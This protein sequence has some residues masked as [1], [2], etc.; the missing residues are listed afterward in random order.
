MESPV[1]G[2]LQ[3]VPLREVWKGEATD[4]TPWLEHNIDVL[5]DAVDLQLSNV[6]RE[7]SAGSFNVD[8]VAEDQN[9]SLVVIE[10][11]LEKSDHDHLGKLITYFTALDARTGIWI[12]SD[13]RPEHV[14]AVGWLNE[15]S[16][17]SFY[18]LKVEAVRIGGSQPAPL[19][20]L[21]TGPSEEAREAGHTKKELAE[22]YVIRQRF[23]TDLLDRS[24][25]RTKL[26]SNISPSQ[27]GWI[28][29]GAGASPNYS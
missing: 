27:S 2:K 11:Q 4:F 21:I 5:N 23:W 8:L 1:I 6:E 16:S 24:K 14:A 25:E 17:G 7:E 9:G 19:L 10:N 29:T 13:P 18:L 12:V 26:F 22:R 28:G 20:T 15:S 3:R